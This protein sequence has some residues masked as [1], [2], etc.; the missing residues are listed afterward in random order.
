[1]K[2]HRLILTFSLLMIIA[3]TVSIGPSEYT[4]P[5]EVQAAPFIGDGFFLCK[6]SDCNASNDTRDFSRSDTRPTSNARANA[7]MTNAADPFVRYA[8][9]NTTPATTQSGRFLNPPAS[10]STAGESSISISP[11]QN[12]V[13]A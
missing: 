10:N 9:P 6:V 2:A 12:A 3:A 1:M 11:S 4:G 7:G 13:V 8:K 5:A